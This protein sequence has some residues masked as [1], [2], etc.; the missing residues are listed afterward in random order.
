MI[1]DISFSLKKLLEEKSIPAPN[2]HIVLGSGLAP[3]F[4]QI[5]TPAPFE[6]IAEIDFTQVAG[7]LPSSVAGHKGSYRIFKNTKTDTTLSFQTGRLHGYEGHDPKVVVQPLVQMALAG[8]SNFLLTN[9]SG[10]L[11]P[12]FHAGSMMIIEDQVNFTGQNPLHGVNSV[13]AHGKEYGPRFPDMSQ[14]FHKE[15]TAQLETTLK[16]AG[17]TPHKGT[18]LGVNGPNF[19]TPAEVKL[20]SSWGMGAVG[21][22]TVWESIALNYLGKK[23]CGLSFISNMGCGLVSGSALSHAEVEEEARKSSPEILRT[24]FKFAENLQP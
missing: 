5:D 10:S 21:M 15:L 24:L 1:S 23:V 6:K 14:G 17:L 11:N 13:D 18:Y 19:E 22:S 9:A 8:T 4:E 3:T 2:L 16:S 20:F 12:D 7:L